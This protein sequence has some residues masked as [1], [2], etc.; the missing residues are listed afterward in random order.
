MRT[1]D[2]IGPSLKSWLD[3]VIV[4]ALVREY[5]SERLGRDEFASESDVRLESSTATNRHPEK[6]P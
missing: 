6:N 2:Q 4:P 3:N 5:L 1:T